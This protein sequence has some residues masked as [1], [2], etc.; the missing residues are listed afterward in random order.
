MP[1]RT[2]SEAELD[3]KD[4]MRSLKEDIA[5]APEESKKLS[6]AD[7]GS[8]MLED[9]EEADYDP[10]VLSDHLA[11]ISRI[12]SQ[13]KNRFFLGLLFSHHHL[14]RIADQSSGDH[15]H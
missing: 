4:I 3:V 15:L 1:E 5:S 7:R 8:Y 9:V 14:V 2:P 6:F 10:D 13:R 11:Y 12:H